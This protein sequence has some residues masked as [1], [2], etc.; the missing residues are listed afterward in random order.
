MAVK[1]GLE[2]AYYSKMTKD[3]KGSALYDV[4]VRLPTVQKVGV[5]PKVNKT[6]VPGD[7][8]IADELTQCLGADIT[9]QRKEFTLEEEA[10]LL[11]RLKDADGG[12]YG[13]T[14][15]NAPYVAFGYKRTFSDNSGLYVWL[16]KTKFAPSNSDAETKPADGITPQYDTLTASSLTREADGQWIYSRYSTDPNFGATFFSK[17]TLEK[18]ANVVSQ[19]Y[20]QPATV[21]SVASLPANGTPGVIYHLQGDDSFHYWNGSAFV[22][23]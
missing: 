19:T 22:E 15:D 1:V 3:E 4:P 9:V 8:I 10:I 17:A 12:V 23:I 5:N 20:G 11:G 21:S 14:K 13:G 7:N 2:E 6:P 16:L 18:L